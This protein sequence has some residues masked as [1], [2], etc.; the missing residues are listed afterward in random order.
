MSRR[1]CLTEGRVGFLTSEIPSAVLSL[2]FEVGSD[3]RRMGTASLDIA[4]FIEIIRS[5]NQDGY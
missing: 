2:G 4:H 1:S 5:A 3:I